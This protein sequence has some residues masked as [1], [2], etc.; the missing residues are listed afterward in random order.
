MYVYFA[1]KHNAVCVAKRKA[2]IIS[3]GSSMAVWDPPSKQT[4][5]VVD[6]SCR[7]H[8]HLVREDA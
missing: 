6:T 5:D 4:S 7:P 2:I 3:R 1:E 8:M